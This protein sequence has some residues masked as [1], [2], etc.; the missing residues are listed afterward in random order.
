MLSSYLQAID[1]RLRRLEDSV[2][3]FTEESIA[4]WEKIE[5]Q[6]K[7]M[8]DLVSRHSMWISAFLVSW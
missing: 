4:K 2:T 7:T 6:W 1:K 3:K 8:E 5:N